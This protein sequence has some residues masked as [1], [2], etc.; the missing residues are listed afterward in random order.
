MAFLLPGEKFQANRLSDP[1]RGP[2]FSIDLSLRNDHNGLPSPLTWHRYC[3]AIYA[4][5]LS[6]QITTSPGSHTYLFCWRDRLYIRTP[7][8]STGTVESHATQ[9]TP[10]MLEKVQTY[11][12][13]CSCIR[14]SPPRATSRNYEFRAPVYL[15][16][17]P[18]SAMSVSTVPSRERQL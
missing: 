9:C 12:V 17:H 6:H 15:T 18:E 1:A 13:L 11:G 8:L 7:Y 16:Q 10:Y 2:F 3:R 14:A 4:D 5:Q